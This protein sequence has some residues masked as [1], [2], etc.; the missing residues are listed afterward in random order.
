MEIN[1]SDV[2]AHQRSP[3]QS[4]K[5]GN[6]KDGGGGGGGWGGGGGGGGSDTIRKRRTADIGAGLYK[7]KKCR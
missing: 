6:K 4:R 5:Q 3:I 7:N 2:L 1:T